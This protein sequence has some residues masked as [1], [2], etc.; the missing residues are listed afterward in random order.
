VAGEV[1][2]LR[3]SSVERLPGERDANFLVQD[4]DGARFVLK[5]VDPA[6]ETFVSRFGT[7]ALIHIA[8]S[9]PSLPTPRVRPPLSGR[10]VRCVSHLAGE[11]SDR[12]AT[13]GARLRNLGTVLA[14][15]DRALA[16]VEDPIE[17][18]NLFWDL[19][20]ADR[21]LGLIPQLDLSEQ[22]AVAAHVLQ[23]FADR[24][25]PQLQ[26]LR[27]QAIHNDFNPQNVL[28]SASA[29]E[30]IVGIIDFGDMVTAPLIQELATACAYY[31]TA[32][33]HPLA[34]AAQISAAFDAVTPLGEVEVSLLPDLI[35]TRL[36]MSVVISESL[37][38]RD[39]DGAAYLRRNR[40]RVV[41]QLRRLEDLPDAQAA[42]W[43]RDRLDESRGL[44]RAGSES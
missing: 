11:S 24:V 7:R 6:E 4:L 42:G 9:D 8:S 32:D 5:L 35:R 23:R 20:R 27:S 44:R 2:G 40:Q 1:F 22:D 25:K 19:K 30:Q 41:G 28:V 36:A 3:I 43:L 31:S 29:P 38:R 16:G 26:G 17:D 13:T 12:T 34:A 14:R 39:P 37:A 18:P 10:H 33:E 15:L 21:L